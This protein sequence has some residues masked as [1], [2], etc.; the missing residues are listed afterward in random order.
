MSTK[1]YLQ[2]V[3]VESVQPGFSLAIRTGGDYRHFQ[4]DCTQMWQRSGQPVMIKLVSEPINGGEPRVLEY[5]A[6]TPVIRLL[7]VCEAAS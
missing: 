7:G 5:E 3:P 4:V 6:G 2:K 1:Y